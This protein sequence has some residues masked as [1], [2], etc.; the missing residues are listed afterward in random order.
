MAYLVHA[1]PASLAKPRVHKSGAQA[2]CTAWLAWFVAAMAWRRAG[3]P[4]AQVAA[5]CI[6]M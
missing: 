4:Q 5:R 1:S 2:P 6:A 3:T